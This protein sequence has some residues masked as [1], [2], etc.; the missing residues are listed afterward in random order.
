MAAY[1]GIT[2][3][4]EE[5]ICLCVEAWLFLETLL[6]SAEDESCTDMTFQHL[7]FTESAVL[8]RARRLS[9]M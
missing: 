5:E 9:E 3:K 6:G 4:M 8:S 7:A 1:P 2:W